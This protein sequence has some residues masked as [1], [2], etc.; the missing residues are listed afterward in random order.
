MANISK[1]ISNF[2]NTELSRPCNFDVLI[3][4]T[5]SLLSTALSP[6]LPAKAL[7]VGLITKGNDFKFKIEA[8]ELPS[9]FFGLVEY[10]TYGPVARTPVNNS[11]DPITLTFI[12]SDDMNERIFFD[13]WMEVISTSNPLGA[14]SGAIAETLSN[15]IDIG[16]GVRYDFEYKD[17][18][19]S[20]III[21]QYDLSGKPTY[22]VALI[23][24]FPYAVSQLPLDWGSRD[25]YHRLRVSFYYTYYTILPV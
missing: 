15:V 25:T 4:P 10:K 22:K 23:E 6:S 5:T 21:T 16:V 18:F 17:N 9:R 8:S 13:L 12:C 24:A 11:Y 19:T 20:T 1:F 2:K 14:L 3:A 7:Q